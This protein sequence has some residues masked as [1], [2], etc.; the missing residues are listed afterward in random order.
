MSAYLKIC[1]NRRPEDVQYLNAHQPD[2]AGFICSKPFWRYV[3]PDSFKALA[4]ELRGGIGR[5]GVFVNPTLSEIAQYAAYLDV[6][7][8]HGEEDADF[9]AD[10]RGYFPEIQIW[11]AARVQTAKDI[12]RADALPVDKLV[13]DSFSAVSHGGTGEVAPWD[14]IV[15]N[16]PEKPFLLAGG[17]TPENVRQALEDVHPWGVDCS[18]G[19]ETDKV[20]DESKIRALVRAVKEGASDGI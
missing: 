5:V 20:K 17:I 2:F 4:R 12:A 1:G 19:V 7:Q 9:I 6:I 15:K 13:L 8:L 11:K 18:S 16:R 3:E 10:L 14:I